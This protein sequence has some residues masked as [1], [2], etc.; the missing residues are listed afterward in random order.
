MAQDHFRSEF[1]KPRSCVH[2]FALNGAEVT[3][4]PDPVKLVEE[5]T[6][7]GRC[8]PRSGVRLWALSWAPQGP[9]SQC[10]PGMGT[11]HGARRPAALGA[12]LRRAGGER[13][14]GGRWAFLQSVDRGIPRCQPSS[15]ARAAGPDW[16][17]R[18]GARLIQRRSEAPARDAVGRGPSCAEGGRPRPC[19]AHSRAAGCV[20]TWPRAHP[21]PPQPPPAARALR[22]PDLRGR[23][24][25]SRGT[26]TKYRPAR[27]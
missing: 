9:G 22:S 1:W 16:R 3:F 24:L 10:R 26:A 21:A 8:N 18:A 19:R 25:F 4:P 20:R 13:M 12:R 17:W 11:A 23:R 15:P 6:W 27:L 7:S 5:P 2:G 14:A